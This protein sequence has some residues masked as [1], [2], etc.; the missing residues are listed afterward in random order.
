LPE[1]E[2]VRLGLQLAEGMAAAHAQGVIHRDLKPGNLRLTKDNRLKILDFGLSWS[3]LRMG[4]SVSTASFNGQIDCSGTL[5]YMATE[6][7]SG[8][9]MDE[10]TDIYSAG[11]VLYE[12]YAGHPPFEHKLLPALV[13]DILHKAPLA[14]S[15]IRPGISP[16]LE[17]IILKC[18]EKDPEKR[19]QSAAELLRELRPLADGVAANAPSRLEGNPRVFLIATA[20]V[21]VM[22]ASIGW[23]GKRWI[24][25]LP[26]PNMPQIQSLAVLP[27]ENLSGDSQQEYLADGITD[28]LTTD[29][30]QMRPLRRIISRTSVMRYKS[31][32]IPLREAARQLNVDAVVEGSVSDAKGLPDA[33]LR[34]Q[35]LGRRLGHRRDL[36][37]RGQH[38]DR[39]LERHQLEHRP[40]PDARR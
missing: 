40:Q 30:G 31:E 9:A 35:R 7:L 23:Y 3:N 26:D 15:R 36:G 5:P 24:H 25:T 38:A 29:L 18:I 12:L 17:A 22:V 33:H 14:P 2:I 1:K 6:Q 11:A 27:F 39:A 16:R 19:Y 20:L 4:P 8:L 37:G 10:R 21:A 13:D 28:F 34:D 32:H